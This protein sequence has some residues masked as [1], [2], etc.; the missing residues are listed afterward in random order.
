MRRIG[1]LFLDI[2]ID[3]RCVLM[4]VQYDNTILLN[5]GLYS[6]PVKLPLANVG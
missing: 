4:C 6:A 1:V 3:E 5:S 2:S